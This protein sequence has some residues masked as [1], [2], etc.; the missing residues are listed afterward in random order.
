M[1]LEEINSELVKIM[2]LIDNINLSK[3]AT[4][5][6]IKK[7]ADMP[8][9]RVE[10]VITDKG[11]TEET[12]DTAINIFG[13]A[14]AKVEQYDAK[15]EY[16][17]AASDKAKRQEIL[18][19]VKAKTEVAQRLK[20]KYDELTR[21]KDVIEKYK[22]KFDIKHI[23]QREE[24][25]LLANNN[26]MASNEARW[27]EI[28][29]FK[30]RIGQELANIGNSLAAIKE[31]D[32][33]EQQLKK[34]EDARDDLE[35]E[36]KDPNADK[37]FIAHLESKIKESES[38]FNENVKKITEKYK[39]FNLNDIQGSIASIKASEEGKIT[40]EKSKIDGKLT[41]AEKKYGYKTGFEDSIRGKIDAAKN[42]EEYA[43]VFDNAQ[44]ELSAE[45]YTLQF[46]NDKVNNNITSI[47]QGEKEKQEGEAGDS[48]EEPTEEEI[49][50]V[51][52]SMPTSKALSLTG[53]ELE[54]AV[55]KYLVEQKGKD[56]NKNHP[57]LK[58][59]SKWQGKQDEWRKSYE[60]GLRTEAIKKIR[61]KKESA[62]NSK[63]E[64]FMTSLLTR[65]MKA[66]DKTIKQMDE[67]AERNPGQ[68]LEDIYKEMDD[69]SAR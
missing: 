3:E 13:Q 9:S 48:K 6:Q 67:A 18:G 26:K 31:L 2:G 29:D 20:G 27:Q 54:D 5:E 53:E 69:D 56:P 55:Y 52:E 25:K 1:T 32:T 64:K 33:L 30:G 4:P 11:F 36:R 62:V 38:K 24:R 49:N 16:D 63:R 8:I 12:L 7:M 17:R 22:E 10:K 46:A 37:S 23:E 40:A 58:W 41:D 45:N 51:I 19:R 28:Q 35:A 15:E 43:K 47:R 61:E 66:D 65:V 59:M 68:V 39:S 21:K 57:I 50:E 34:L 42:D 44:M 14:K 60:E